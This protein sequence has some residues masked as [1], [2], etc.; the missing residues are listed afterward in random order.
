MATCMLPSR[1][2]MQS[3]HARIHVARG[4]RQCAAGGTSSLGRGNPAAGPRV[5]AASSLCRRSS[6]VAPPS[7]SAAREAPVAEEAT[8]AADVAFEAV[9]GIETHVQINTRTK[10]FCRCAAVFGDEP[11]VHTCPVCM[12]F[13]GTLPVLS[14]GVVH[15]A[16]QLGLGLNCT[17]RRRSTFDRKQY[18]YPDLPKGYQ[19]SQFEEPYG[20]HG[21]IEVVVPVEDG[22][23]VRSIGITRAHMEED[24]GKLTHF[25]AVGSVP[26]YALADYNR[27]GVALV[28]IVSEPDMRTGREVAAY[29]AEIRRLVRYLDVGDGNLSEGSMRCDVNVSVRPVGRQAFGTKVEVKNMNSF[30]AMSRAVD[31]EIERQTALIRAGKGHEVVQET[32]TWDEGRQSTVSMRAKGGEADYRYFPEPDLPALVFDETFMDECRQSMPELPGAIRTRYAALGLP[33]A[34]VQVLVEDK[35]LVAYFDAA[36]QAGAPAKQAA[37]WLTGDVMAYLKNTKDVTISTLSST[38]TPAALAEFCTM[39]DDG[40]ISGKIGKDIL[41]DL[42]AGAGGDGGEGGKSPRE[43]VEQRGLSQI[44]DPAAIEAIVAAVLAANPGQLEQYRGGKD[45]L[46]GFFVGAVLKASGG[47]ANPAMSNAILMRKL[48]GE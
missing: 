11:N 41:P 33:P 30:N 1:V 43:I 8:G 26:G 23:G 6:S 48:K 32:R 19:I 44:S 31:F 45:K 15:K 24:A 42:L 5:L 38:L 39:V 13:P 2:P 18:F 4:T 36:L 9:I 29:G 21:V 22:G 25:P 12:G 14:Q 17:I 35:E 37:N 28:E 10:A 40:T 47:R 34:D 46:K 16:V 7:A 20:E 27:A 3:L